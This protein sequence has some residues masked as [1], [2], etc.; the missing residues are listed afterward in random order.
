MCYSEF[1][2][3]IES[4]TALDAD[5][6]T[7]ETSRSEMELL[8]AFVDFQ[9]PNEIGPDIYDTHS[10]RVPSREEMAFLLTKASN[11]LPI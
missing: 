8:N 3:I 9:Y 5:I 10:L 4:V 6:I 7:I 2:D 1:N 11:L